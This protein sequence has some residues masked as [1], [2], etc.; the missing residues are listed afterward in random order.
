MDPAEIESAHR[1]LVTKSKE[2][3]E[4]DT[5]RKWCARALAAYQLFMQSGNLRWL[6]DA[7]TYHGEAIEH[8]AHADGDH[9]MLTF[10]ETAL[11]AA[12]RAAGI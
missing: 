5:A 9:T 4:A 3:I 10:V 2:E 11:N 1:E 7:I 6:N 12:Q 8:A